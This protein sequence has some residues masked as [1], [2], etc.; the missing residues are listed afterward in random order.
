MRVEFDDP[1]GLARVG[2]FARVEITSEKRLAIMVPKDAVVERGPMKMVF[3]VN[4]GTVKQ[5]MVNVLR[6][7]GD[8]VEVR[9]ELNAGDEVV[10]TGNEILRDGAKVNVTLK[11]K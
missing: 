9:G 10:V 2:L 3:A 4:D 6:Q 7:K 5:V 8:M 11:R 1:K